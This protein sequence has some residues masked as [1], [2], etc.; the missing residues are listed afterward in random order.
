MQYYEL[1]PEV[2]QKDAEFWQLTADWQQKVSNCPVNLWMQ[3]KNKNW[4][5]YI[6]NYKVYKYYICMWI[7]KR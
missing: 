6:M 7:F 1:H 5:W 3:T 4:I 2:R